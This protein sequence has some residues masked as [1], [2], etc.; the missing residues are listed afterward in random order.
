VSYAFFRNLYRRPVLLALSVVASLTVGAL[1]AATI[2]WTR[3]DPRWSVF[4]AGVLFAAVLATASR[5][6]KAE[7]VVVRRT[8]QIDR[9]R[10]KLAEASARS[11]NATEAFKTMEAR[12]RALGD[13]L[14]QPVLLCDREEICRF[15]NAAA[16]HEAHATGQDLVGKPLREIFG[17]AAYERMQPHLHA[18]FAGAPVRYP[19]AWQGNP[20]LV[21]QLA[22]A[23]TGIW[24]VLER[25]GAEAA[26]HPHAPAA[27]ASEEKGD[28]IYLRAIARELTGWDD[29]RAKLTKALA[30]DRFLFY[31][32][33]I[34]PLE[35]GGPDPLCYEI[36]LR[37]QEEEDHLLPPGGFLPEA[38]HFGLMG[39]ID[40]WV[41]RNLVTWC[42]ARHRRE[43]SWQLP[44]YCVNLSAAAVREA[45]FGSYVQ[46]QIQRGFPGRALCF[47]IGEAEVI[48]LPEES[49]RLVAML[50]P[51]GC[52]FTVDA[53]GSVKGSFAPLR[54]LP[55]NFLKID[56]VIVQNM[57]RD[58]AQLARVRAIAAACRR[59]G[60][61]TIAEF[62]EDDET[63][64]HLR[65]AG[66][67]Y[68][69]GFGVARP[70]PIG[71]Q[72]EDMPAFPRPA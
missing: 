26:S 29:P 20:Y 57:R 38:E 71:A 45:S 52:R 60:L 19:L 27:R 13:A 68:V 37:L 25:A 14:T 1:L 49:R 31:E 58:P 65:R 6:S 43:P 7:W 22:H 56:G 50:K 51:F 32:Q 44:L 34:L 9:L 21:R 23:A 4:L 59:T 72:Q 66:V 3:F 2:Y 61:R 8:R 41:I 70:A 28:A 64:A 67:D 46:K 17:D 53:F 40:R 24:L 33:K 36:L 12:A 10:A 18:S 5:A 54:G 30:E 47:E 63:F 69:Q 16:A 42:L 48:A 62:V 39:E 11:A 15:H 35:L 55:V